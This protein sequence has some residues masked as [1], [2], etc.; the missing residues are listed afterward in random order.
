MKTNEEIFNENINLAY[1]IANKYATNFADE[2]EDI[3]QIALIGLWKA[4][5]T[6]NQEYKLSTYAYPCISNEILMYIRKN[7]RHRMNILSIDNEV[8]SSKNG[9]NVKLIDMIQDDNDGIDEILSNMVLMSYLKKIKT[10]EFTNE[11]KTII[12]FKLEG[13]TQTEISKALKCSQACIS[14]K[15]NKLINKIKQYI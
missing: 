3:Q 5:M 12:K 9:D 4:V 1:K 15:C 7:M 11:E 8:K 2:I 14:R 10:I 6:W 13:K